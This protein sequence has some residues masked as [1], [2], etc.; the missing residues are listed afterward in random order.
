[1][2]SGEEDIKSILSSYSDMIRNMGSN[3]HDSYD[4]GIPSQEDDPI[5][6]SNT[7]PVS[8]VN[9]LNVEA[10][11]KKV[12]F[13]ELLSHESI[14]GTD[15]KIPKTSVEEV[16]GRMKNTLY[17]YF[18]G[19][20][21]A[22]PIVEN[23]VWNAWSKFGIQKVM[24]NTQGFFFFKFATQQG[25]E[26]ALEAGPWMTRNYSKNVDTKVYINEGGLDQGSGT[27]R[28]LDSYT[29]TM[30][31]ESWGRNSY[32]RAMVELS[33]EKELV[34]NLVAA[35]PLL[36]EEVE[37]SKDDVTTDGFQQ[38]GSKH[39]KTKV[40]NQ[41]VTS[42]SVG[43]VVINKTKSKFAYRP[44]VNTKKVDETN[45]TLKSNTYEASTSKVGEKKKHS[46]QLTNAFSA[47][48]GSGW[49]DGIWDDKNAQ[50][51]A[52]ME[53]D[54][55]CEQVYDETG[56]F[57][58]PNTDTGNSKGA[59]TP[60]VEKE[61]RQV[62]NDNHL[63]VCAILE[64][65]VDVSCLSN[66]C[67]RVFSRWRWTSNGSLC[68]KGSRIIP[69]WD[70][71][72]VDIMI[73][74][75]TDQVMH[76]Q[77]IIKADKKM[78]FC[79]FVY[80]GNEYIQRRILWHNLEVHNAHV[81][82]HS[83]V[84]MGDFNAALNLEDCHAGSS[85]ISISM[86][87]FKE[88]VGNIEVQDV[89]SSGLHYTWNQKPKGRGGILKKL[90]RVMNNLKFMDEFV[91]TYAIFQP[92][93]ISD[94]SP[95]VLK[96]PTL[97]RS[98]PK[99]FKFANFLVYKPKFSDIIKVEWEKQVDGHMMFHIIS[100]LKTLKSQFRKLLKDQRN[101]HLRVEQ[102]R[103][104]LDEAQKVV[105]FKEIGLMLFGIWRI[106]S[107]RVRLLQWRLSNTEFF[108]GVES[109]TTPL[110]TPDLFYK[111]LPSDVRDSMV[112]VITNDE[113]KQAMFS[114]GD[115]RAPGPDGY[116]SAFFKKGW[117]IV[118]NDERLGLIVS[119]NQSAFVPGRRI[120]DNILLTQELMHSYHRDIGPPRC[121]FKIDIQKAYDTVDWNFL[122]KM[123]LRQGDP[124]SPYLFTLVM[125]VLTL[126]F[127]K[128]VDDSNVFRYHKHCERQQ[129][130]NL[131]FADDLFLFLYGNVNSAMVLMDSLEDFKAMSGLVPSIPKSTVFFCNVTN[132]VKTSIL[133][134]MPF[135]E[136]KLPVKYL[137]VPLI[138][139]R[140]IYKDCKVLVENV[141]NRIVD[142]K[143]KSLSFAGRLQ[144][145][146]VLSSMHLYWAS[147]LILPSRIIQ[148]LEQLMRGFLWCQGDMKRG[149]PK[150]AWEAIC[151]P[152]N[153]GGLG[154]RRLETFNL[155][156]MAT[157]I[158]S[159]VMNKESLWVRWI[160]S[161]KL[162]GRSFW[163]VPMRSCVSWRWRKLFQIRDTIRPFLWYQIG[164]GSKAFVWF[165]R[166]CD[167]C[168][169]AHHKIVRQIT[170]H[171][172]SMNDKVVDVVHN[173][174]WR[175]QYDWIVIQPTVLDPNKEDVLVWKDIHGNLKP[176]SVSLVWDSIRPRKALVPWVNIVWF[177]QC[178]P[179][180]AFHMWLVM[181]NKL[182][183]QD[184][185]RQ[186]D[187]S[188]D[189]NLNVLRCPLCKTQPDSHSHLFFECQF[190]SHVWSSC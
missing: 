143:N 18:I 148:D 52:A 183:T 71:D 167:E 132:Q 87:E 185:L 124:M 93:R 179:C 30:C 95:A 86:R 141:H 16:K 146:P 34:T 31:E 7:K 48:A 163:D 169:L 162:M 147:V 58:K 130:V 49:E 3:K 127:R 66:I 91:G 46:I 77:V 157:H 10:R 180:H 104:E 134:M 182:K 67:S 170:N 96:I 133:S 186:W 102:L 105:E 101:L 98:K 2:G 166:W 137:G 79:S 109:A 176:F 83:W 131:C 106:T 50:D 55:E 82:G 155:S 172:F 129:I 43:G 138:S 25:M 89:N 23:Y 144:L 20:R 120:S 62:V 92:Y 21:L 112:R 99:P 175:W 115:N 19:K 42:K 151:F 26:D 74:S 94:H 159:I 72:H 63:D 41:N 125:E 32:A 168:P 189:S 68:D 160:H 65:H 51:T 121:A 5:S 33:S 45:A 36:E 8:Y 47:L 70:P 184:V 173:G 156:L 153:E 108:L 17:G 84:L 100:K 59:S 165:D 139:S 158:W 122:R 187:V 75:Q 145:V 128:R 14:D 107:M 97:C 1:M 57:M 114:I 69:G 85:R 38:I 40:G 103:N 126:M 64:Y 178:I 123:G 4:G 53:S 28:M 118:G 154:I 81:C 90:D 135:N 164:S 117:D 161:Y 9:A 113:I 27:S 142:W 39:G 11:S 174:A 140:L 35:I 152:K 22:F 6:D 116:L 37:K 13:H 149:K 56:T 15:L 190:S 44:K 24:M 136:G 76:T 78:L 177:S 111:Q 181:L 61:V 80:A 110:Q 171:G 188:C 60:V 73:V 54:D 88:C 119:D 12:N 29:T 150:V